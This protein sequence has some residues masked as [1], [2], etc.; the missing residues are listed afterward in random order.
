MN[1]VQ[2]GKTQLD[3]SFFKDV[4]APYQLSGV[5]KEYQI[6]GNYAKVAIPLN[7]SKVSAMEQSL[8][9]EESHDVFPELGDHKSDAECFVGTFW[10]TVK[11]IPVK[12]FLKKQNDVCHYQI[13]TN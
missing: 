4:I 11:K 3:E 1:E 9:I 10:T 5:L 7:C 2:N 13:I 6:N 12:V 8:E